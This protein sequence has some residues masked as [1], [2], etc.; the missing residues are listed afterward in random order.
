MEVDILLSR[1]FPPAGR[2]PVAEVLRRAG[3]QPS[4]GSG[5]L[6]VW[7]RDIETGEKLE[8]LV[9]HD[10][11]AR[12]VGIPV[13]FDDQD[14]IKAIPLRNLDLLR[15]FKQ[16]MVISPTSANDIPPLV[17]WLPTLGA[18]VV[19]KAST[20]T[21]RVA[22][23]GGGQPKAAKDLLYLRDLMAAGHEVVEQI[24]QDLTAMVDDDDEGVEWWIASV[25]QE[26]SYTWRFTESWPV[27][28]MT[29]HGC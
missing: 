28:L 12:G 26:T 25:K 3:F 1:P 23:R 5:G 8:F 11:I 24:R 22:I 15:R 14:G 18:Y 6:A 17:I 13:R 19:N 21:D 27:F 4:E 10:G 29:H 2:Q 20:F 7:E 9:A 16:R